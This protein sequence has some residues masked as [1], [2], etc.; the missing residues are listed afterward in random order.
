MQLGLALISPY[1]EVRHSLWMLSVEIAESQVLTRKIMVSSKM[2]VASHLAFK[3]ML[4]DFDVR[5]DA[6]LTP[7]L[8]LNKARSARLQNFELSCTV[9]QPFILY[10]S[11]VLRSLTILLSVSSGNT[12]CR[13]SEMMSSKPV[14]LF[15]VNMRADS[16]FAFLKRAHRTSF[17][18]CTQLL[19]L[20]PWSDLDQPK[21]RL[22]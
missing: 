1:Q 5:P 9:L 4:A 11:C 3:T 13:L 19:K 21:L 20:R 6:M 15:R 12:W 17:M 8:E 7:W 18:Q 16:S 22:L 14:C 2:G 10:L